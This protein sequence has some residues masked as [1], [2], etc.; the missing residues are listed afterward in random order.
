MRIL[1]IIRDSQ[2][3]IQMMREYVI[4]KLID[5]NNKRYI[6]WG[7][8]IATFFFGFAAGGMLHA[9]LLFIGSSFV[10]KYRASLSYSSAIF[11]DGIIFPIINMVAV[12][13]LLS[14]KKYIKNTLVI[15]A[16][17]LGSAITLYFHIAQALG[18]IVN[19][20][21][22]QPWHWN[23]LGVWHAMYMFSVASFLSLFYLV[24]ANIMRKEKILPKEVF[25][26]TTGLVLFF[27][28]L[29]LDYIAIDLKRL[30]P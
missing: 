8:G 4:T 13:F 22:P 10:V 12:S 1:S 5:I 9:Y 17:F 2:F 7:V 23:I 30:L 20:S 14:N 26:V 27:I 19:W 18:G 25:F 3:L 15:A 11:G 6:I 29:R 21:M 24:V 16:L 28:L